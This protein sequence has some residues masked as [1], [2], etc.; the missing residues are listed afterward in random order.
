MKKGNF[1]RTM[2]LILTLY[3]LVACSEKRERP[4]SVHVSAE[5]G[6]DAK[7]VTVTETRSVERPDY[8]RQ[9]TIMEAT[10]SVDVLSKTAGLIQGLLVDEGDRVS[11]GQVLAKLD[12]GEAKL[13]VKEAQVHLLQAQSTFARD[14]ELF[15][16]KIRS[17]KDFEQSKFQLE[18]AKAQL[19]AAQMR[20][21]Y[22][23]I[24]APF[25]GVVVERVIEEGD[26][27]S[28][29]QKVFVL[30]ELGPLRARVYLPEEEIRRISVGSRV[31][32]FVKSYPEVAFHG[33]VTAM[34]P[35]V[36]PESGTNKV[37]VEIQDG[38]DVLKPGMFATVYL[39]YRTRSSHLLVPEVVFRTKGWD[40][41]FVFEDGKARKRIVVPGLIDSGYVEILS[42][43][44]ARDRVII[45]GSE[46][47]Q[48][49]QRVTLR[50]N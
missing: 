26:M 15:Q 30:A 50:S 48:N 16:K 7:T 45:E 25:S 39:F 34:S 44:T 3:L 2:A 42:G 14:E 22:T 46:G 12:E 49:G 47:L 11:S 18:I 41:V 31:K 17:E 36:D 27:M 32:I 5:V 40:E 13:R 20:L 43:L 10:R 1:K 23:R 24:A 8:I 28:P 19:E 6:D 4:P 29:N 9:N 35:V 37:T 21:E 33:Q 38:Q